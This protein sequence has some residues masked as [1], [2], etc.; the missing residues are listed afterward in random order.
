MNVL[1]IDTSTERASVALSINGEMNSLEQGA[2]RQH[3]QLLLP[4]INQLLAEAEISFSQLD[5]LVYGQGPGSFTGL[6]IA[7]SVAKGLAYAHDRPLFP[8]SS[9]A[10]IAYQVIADMNDLELTANN[11][12]VLA[13]IDARMNQVYWGSFSQNNWKAEEKVS[14]IEDIQLNN[15]Q[16]FILAGVG[17]EAYL[18]DLPQSVCP[19][20]KHHFTMYP[21]AQAMIRIALSGNIQAINAADA[22][23]LYIRNH[24]TQGE[25]RG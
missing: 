21:Q 4:M 5:A 19:L 15:N 25:S 12:A 24:V 14:N 16:P 22:L 13:I 8:V 17:Y 20:I 23:P 6:R 1:A 18:A 3:A 7:C 10:A 11:I 2:Q 9:L